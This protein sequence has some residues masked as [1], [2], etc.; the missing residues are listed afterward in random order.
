MGHPPTILEI[1][2]QEKRIDGQM[3]SIC[4]APDGGALSFGNWNSKLHVSDARTG[5]LDCSD[6]NWTSQY[7]VKLSGI[8]VD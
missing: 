1:E 5:E 8:D 4:V 7:K 2:Q 6:M 3:F